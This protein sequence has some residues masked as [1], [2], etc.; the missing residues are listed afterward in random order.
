MNISTKDIV[1]NSEI[2]KNYK[3][4]REKAE[5]AGKIFIFKNNK[6]DAVMVQEKGTSFLEEPSKKNYCWH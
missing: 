2:I 5:G 1:S 3:A 6:P 4:C